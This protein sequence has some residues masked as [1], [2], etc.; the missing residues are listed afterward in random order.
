[1]T[2]VDDTF[3]RII[4]A[5][6]DTTNSPLP[7]YFRFEEKGG[8]THDPLAASYAE[9][10]DDNLGFMIDQAAREFPDIRWAPQ[11]LIIKVEP[12]SNFAM[13]KEKLIDADTRRIALAKL[14]ER[15]RRVLGL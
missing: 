11:R 7:R 14:S 10:L 13:Y 6:A 8:Q 1:M 3:T 2:I 5:A 12:F 4:L 9:N 15:E